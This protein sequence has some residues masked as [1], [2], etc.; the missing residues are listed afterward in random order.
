[1][2]VL[3]TERL[4][5]RQVTPADAADLYRIYTD[6]ENMKF[7]GRQ[8]DSIEFE[9][10]HIQKHIVNYYEKYGFGLWATVL[11]PNNQLIGRCGLLYQQIEGSQELE[12]TY[13]LD[14]S[15]WG[16][17][18][19]TEAARGIIRLGFEKYQFPRIVALINPDNAASVRV[20]EKIG[21]KYERDVSYKEFGTVAMYVLEA[22]SFAKQ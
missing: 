18:L 1:M 20:A 17:G 7:M 9:R 14:K 8:P 22:R 19:T 2:N 6:P 5:L 12:V 11:K 15:Y 13:L 16:R 10:E 3:E 21:M 4:I